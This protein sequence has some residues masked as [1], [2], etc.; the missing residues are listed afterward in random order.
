MQGA[1]V[2]LIRR[3]MRVLVVTIGVRYLWAGLA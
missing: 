3:V 2:L 1:L